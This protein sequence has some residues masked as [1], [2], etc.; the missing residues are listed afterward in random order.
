MIN[1][2]GDWVFQEASRQAV[3]WR[4]WYHPNFQVS[5]NKSPVQFQH[6]GT[7][8]SHW[9]D[10]LRELGLPGEGIAVEITEGL[11]LDASPAVSNQLLELRES[12]IEVGIDDFGTGYSS[13]A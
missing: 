13:L 7:T 6:G 12:G 2:I 1:E 10:F 8:P 5:I 9:Q 3:K 11:L 4:A